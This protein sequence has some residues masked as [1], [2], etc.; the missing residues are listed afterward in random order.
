MILVTG[1]T[2]MLGK[3]L[4]KILSENRITYFTTSRRC[5]VKDCYKIDL[6]N[7]EY[8]EIKKAMEGKK[9][10]FH[11]ASD[12]KR[13]S[14]AVDVGGTEKLVQA[15]KENKIEHFIYISI[16]GIENVPLGYYKNKLGAEKV[17]AHSGIPYTI[18]RSTQFHDFIDIILTK[19]LKGPIILLPKRFKI[20]PI[21]TR[22]VAMEMFKL[23]GSEAQNKIL[24]IGGPEVLTLEEALLKRLKVMRMN[25]AI[26]NLP[27]FGKVSSQI[28]RGSLTCI[29][30][31]IESQIW[32]EYVE[33]KYTAAS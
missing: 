22:V 16:V 29:E 27:L 28:R 2:G 23:Y 32:E 24:N 19:L 10:I 20:Q 4:V 25:K 21:D 15:A 1:G 18:L 12:T 8:E 11:L 33:K 7:A 13:F 31:S 5:D 9:I 14:K 26:L 30:E 17:I 3:E 6:K